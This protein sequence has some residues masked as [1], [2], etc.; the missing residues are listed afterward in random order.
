MNKKL[1]GR[2]G[3]GEEEEVVFVMTDLRPHVE[4][5][6]G[7][8]KKRESK[9]GKKGGGG[10]GKGGRGGTLRY[11]PEPVDAANAPRD[12]VEKVLGEDGA[13]VGKKKKKKKKVMRLFSLAFHHFDDELALGIL[14]NTVER[15]DGFWYVKKQNNNSSPSPPPFPHTPNTKNRPH[16]H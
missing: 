9:E 4:A 3:E 7:E 10:G 8:V 16:S 14:R 11:V 2:E 12:L 5:W 13:R 6:E 1:A 15:G